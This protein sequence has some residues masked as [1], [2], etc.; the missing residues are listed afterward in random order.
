MPQEEEGA[1]GEGERGL[2]KMGTASRRKNRSIGSTSSQ[3]SGRSDCLGEG[4][5]HGRKEAGSGVA[6]TEE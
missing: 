4:S 6:W 2:Q 1:V 5:I 3:E